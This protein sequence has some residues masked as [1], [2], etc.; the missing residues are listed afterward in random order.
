MIYKHF[1][2]ENNIFQLISFPCIKKRKAAVTTAAKGAYF[3]RK[4]LQ[5][6]HWSMAGFCSWVPTRMLSREQ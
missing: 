4:D 1:T 6:V 3:L 5:S 2:K